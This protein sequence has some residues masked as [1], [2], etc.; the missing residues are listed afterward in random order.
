MPEVLINAT[1][2]NARVTALAQAIGTDISQ[3]VLGYNTRLAAIEAAATSDDLTEA[4]ATAAA[5]AKADADAIALVAFEASTTT[6]FAAIPAKIAA[7]INDASM[8]G[9]A[10]TWS[11]DK[12]TA[13]VSAAITNGLQGVSA[14]TL[15]VLNNLA[16]ELAADQNSVHTIL[17][18]LARSVSYDVQ[19]AAAADMAQARANIGA[20]SA[21]ET[22]T[23]IA[24]ALG[25][26]PLPF[27]DHDFAADYR[28]ARGARGNA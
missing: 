4:A 17:G 5:L 1:E 13:Y 20:T 11:V 22:A 16:A 12:I 18:L 7:L 6:A 2:F 27:L 26:L 23:A 15:A 8:T 3:L 24:L 21:A 25:A 10:V 28:G 14:N 19:T 9:G